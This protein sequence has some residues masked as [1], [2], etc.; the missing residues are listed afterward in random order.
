[1]L[2][3]AFGVTRRSLLNSSH[4]GWQKFSGSG[5]SG[6]AYM[7]LK[8]A[9]GFGQGIARSFL[10]VISITTPS[11]GQA[12]FYG[13]PCGNLPFYPTTALITI[14][15]ALLQT[16]GTHL[17]P[18]AMKSLPGSLRLFAFASS[19]F[20]NLLTLVG[21]YLGGCSLVVTSSSLILFLTVRCILRLDGGEF[22]FRR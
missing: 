19:T 16:A 18:C 14:I 17:F 1:M 5:I 20:L 9:V 7:A 10:V 13:G 12:S 4:C 2:T 15:I 22:A 11:A 8:L 21:L 3:A 6:S